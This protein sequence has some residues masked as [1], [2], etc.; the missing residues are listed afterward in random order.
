MLDEPWANAFA[1]EWIAAWNAHDLARIF[2]LYVDDFEMRSPLIIERMGEPSGVL[3]G[4]ENIRPYWAQGLAAQ[5]PLIFELLYVLVGVDS[6]TIC[7]QSVGRRCVAEVLTFNANRMV[8]RGAAYYGDGGFNRAS[9][10][11]SSPVRD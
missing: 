7:Y 3:R 2:S 10:P 1:K 6:V 8:V 4:K 5:P 11:G 9:V